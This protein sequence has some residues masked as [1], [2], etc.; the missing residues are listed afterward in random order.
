VDED[1]EELDDAGY[2]Q[3]EGQGLQIAQAQRLE[4]GVLD[5]PGG[6]SRDRAHEN[7]REAHARGGF[8]ALRHADERAQAEQLDQNEI[9]D[10]GVGD[11][12]GNVR[13]AASY[14][15][16]IKRPCRAFR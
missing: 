5:G 16:L 1:F 8:G 13:H 12:Y 4:Y 3:D 6:Q 11:D 15:F 7:H 9:V 10:E 2:D 14:C